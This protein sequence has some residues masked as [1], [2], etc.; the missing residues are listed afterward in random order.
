MRNPAHNLLHVDSFPSSSFD[1]KAYPLALEFSINPDASPFLVSSSKSLIWV[2][3]APSGLIRAAFRDNVS[4]GSLFQEVVTAVSDM[5]AQYEWGNVHS[6]TYNGV[7]A[8]AN[9]IR[10]YGFQDVEILA[11]AGVVD[12]I[13][14]D[15]SRD[16]DA[17]GYYRVGE[18]PVPVVPWLEPRWLV[19]VPRDRGFVGF[20]AWSGRAVVAVIHNPSR[21]IGIARSVT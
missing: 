16:G 17:Y 4:E 10:S 21:G 19:V 14:L 12:V 8:A 5:G 20:T 2:P 18:M 3:E 13:G 7:D 6:L 1:A 11:G 9:H 15:P